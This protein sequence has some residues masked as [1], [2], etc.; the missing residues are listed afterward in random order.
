M[1]LREI[2]RDETYD[3]V[4][5]LIEGLV[6]KFQ[7]RHGGEFDELM[8]EAS[9]LYTELYR[10]YQ[11]KYPFE[12]AIKFVV[13]K[14]LLSKARKIASRNS[15]LPRLHVEDL[16]GMVDRHHFDFERFKFEV[17]EDAATVAKIAVECPERVEALAMQR[18]GLNS[19]SSMRAAITIYLRD[20][21]W[22]AARIAESFLEI[23]SALK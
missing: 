6:K 3:E 5:G 16:G 14:G 10:N 13:W 8:G 20:L 2:A 21:G 9:I 1:G 23:G 12:Q 7:Y 17:S 15:N 11:R 22:T 4:K 19:P 18:R